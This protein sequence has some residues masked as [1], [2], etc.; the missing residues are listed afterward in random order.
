MSRIGNWLS[1]LTRRKTNAFEGETEEK[2]ARVL[3]LLDLSFLGIGSTLGLGVYVLA[4][5][6]ALE[7]GPAVTISFLIAAIASAFAGL[8][9]AELASR[10]PKAGSAYVYCYVTIGEFAAFAIG[11]N[12]ILEYTI[13]TAA[14]AKAL[15]KA[16]DYY[17]NNF[18]NSTLTSILPMNMPFMA[19]YVDLFAFGLVSTPT[20]LL[21]FGAKESSVVNNILTLVNILTVLIVII[22]GIFKANAS[23]WAISKKDIPAVIRGKQVEGGSGGFLP[24]GWNG[25]L[26]G[27]ARCFFG[28]VG[29]DVIATTGEEAKNPKRNVPLALIISL[30][31]I[32]MAYFGIATVITML[33]PYY[34]QDKD[35]SLIIAF[36][37]KLPVIAVIVGIGAMS[38]LSASLLGAI[39]PLPRIL[40]SM[41]NDGLLFSSFT[42][43]NKFTRTPLIA[44]VVSGVLSGIF[45]AVFNLDALTELMSLGTLLAYSIVA[46]CI[47]IIRYKEVENKVHGSPNSSPRNRNSESNHF[48]SAV[49][50][51]SNRN[52]TARSEKMTQWLLFFSMI[53]ITMLCFILVN[54]N[55]IFEHES[56][57]FHGLIIGLSI[58]C[59]LC[60]IIICWQPQN[61]AFASFKVPLVPLVPICSIFMNIYL[62]MTFQGMTW[63]LFI[64]WLIVGFAI[65]FFYS[66]NHSVEGNTRRNIQTDGYAEVPLNC[67]NTQM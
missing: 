14:V 53:F 25:V 51:L 27:A 34:A 31:V 1:Q 4:G 40:Y 10:V 67:D 2:L 39:F 5:E 28:Y 44:T 56:A 9:F 8:C 43:V 54:G 36:E 32:F 20:A 29:F 65:Y 49:K 64:I 57:L 16:V 55:T 66:L 58:L 42:N 6:V 12:L 19:P 52:P 17:A 15:S 18:I 7:A 21:A 11:W 45:A 22:A 24:F 46:L 35:K 60:F 38:A 62:M 63:V 50:A 61:N 47:L 26:K 37:D 33:I 23:Y 3:G 30:V 59:I 41:A 13:G 48:W